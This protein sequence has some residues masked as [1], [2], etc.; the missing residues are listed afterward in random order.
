[1]AG[2]GVM[3]LFEM[4]ILVVKGVELFGSCCRSKVKLLTNMNGGMTCYHEQLP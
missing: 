1:M 4:G 3:E 2:G